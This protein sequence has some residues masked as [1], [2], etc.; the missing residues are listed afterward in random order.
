[1]PS[2]RTAELLRQTRPWVRFLGI[3]GFVMVALM[4]VA[5]AVMLTIA[6]VGSSTGGVPAGQFVA[7]GVMYPLM[8]LL[9]V[10]PS[11]F[12]LRYASRISDFLDQ[13][14]T[15]ALDAALEAQKSFWKFVGIMAAII[16]ALYGVILLFGL[17][18]GLIAWVAAR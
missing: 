6:I 18:G 3:L 4:F 7:M 2:A 14:T 1:M 5:G 12:L 16:M 9:Y 11:L 8:S 15:E 17:I 10:F 13:G